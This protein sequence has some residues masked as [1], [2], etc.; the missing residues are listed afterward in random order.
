MLIFPNMEFQDP[1]WPGG[2]GRACIVTAVVPTAAADEAKALGEA[3]EGLQVVTAAW[4]AVSFLCKPWLIT[5][6][7]G[8]NHGLIFFEQFCF[9]E[10]LNLYK[11]CDLW[12]CYYT[13]YPFGTCMNLPLFAIITLQVIMSRT[14]R[15]KWVL[16]SQTFAKVDNEV[17]FRS[18]H[19]LHP[20]R[21]AKW[22]LDEKELC[23]TLQHQRHERHVACNQVALFWGTLRFGKELEKIDI[24][25]YRGNY[26]QYNAGNLSSDSINQASNIIKYLQ[27]ISKE[28]MNQA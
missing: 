27:I 17:S 23:V 4:K 22:P 28:L 13:D 12:C 6:Q 11:P 7:N 8:W 15:M 3:L 16:S 25:K 26:I 20:R 9:T 10:G 1:I 18:S 21:T 19:K 2:S 5:N 14:G 24:P